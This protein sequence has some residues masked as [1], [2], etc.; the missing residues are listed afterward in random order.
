MRN[1]MRLNITVVALLAL[2]LLGGCSKTIDPE[3]LQLRGNLS[4]EVNDPDPY[5]G[6]VVGFYE[7]GQKLSEVNY[8]DGKPVGTEVTWH[9]NGQTRGEV[10]FV[11][12]KKQGKYIFL[13]ENGQKAYEVNYVDG[14]LQG[15]SIQWAEDG[16]KHKETIWVDGNPKTEIIYSRSGRVGY[17]CHFDDYGKRIKKGSC[18]FDN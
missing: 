13:D 3:K 10:S 15:E 5:S 1:A 11:D 4:Y 2:L 17:M 18:P 8:V 9:E 16:H 7:N 12:G 14:K 6:K